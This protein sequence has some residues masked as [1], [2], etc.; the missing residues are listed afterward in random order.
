MG[1]GRERVRPDQF[2]RWVYNRMDGAYAA[3]PDYP[4]ALIQHIAE[5]A[6]PVPAAIADVGAGIGHLSVPL[7]AKGHVVHAIEPAEAMLQALRERAAASGVQLDAL[8]AAAESLPLSAAS[9]D[10]VLVA[11]ALHFFDAHRAGLELARVLRRGGHLVFVRVELAESGYMRA[12]SEL[13]REA[14][15]RRPKQTGGSLTQ[16]AALCGVEITLEACFESRMALDERRLERILGSISFLG[17]A[18]NEQRFTAFLQR[19][20]GIPGPAVWET[21]VRLSAG[22][23]R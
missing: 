14:A 10:L 17:P 1:L 3:R 2:E 13:M 5:L 9:M 16:V 12:L 4:A 7:A 15:P 6:G 22:R 18:M 19:A 8:H 11:D 21:V 20:R 23:R